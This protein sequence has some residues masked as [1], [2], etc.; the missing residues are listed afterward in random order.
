M[1][2]CLAVIA[3]AATVR[4]KIEIGVGDHCGYLIVPWF[5]HGNIVSS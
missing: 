5:A 3:V 1:R 4:T 2:V